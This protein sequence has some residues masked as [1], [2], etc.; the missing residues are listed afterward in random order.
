M[1]IKLKYFGMVSEITETG[2][3]L[4]SVDESIDIKNL[5]LLLVSK[6]DLLSTINYKVA[7]NQ[8][9]KDDTENLNENDEVVLLPPFAGG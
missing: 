8:S 3:E 2:E 5:K 9:I 6:Y 1:N 7:V 4:L